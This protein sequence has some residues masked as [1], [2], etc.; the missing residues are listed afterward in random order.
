MRRQLHGVLE[1]VQREV[2]RAPPLDHQHQGLAERLAAS[3]Q[4]PPPPLLLPSLPPALEIQ[5]LVLPRLPLLAALPPLAVLPAA[6][7]L[8]PSLP[9]CIS[10]T[11]GL[12]LSGTS[13]TT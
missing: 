8:L 13:N 9:A 6:A 5:P 7:P 4:W 3:L 12:R 10:L 1:G 11:T 2:Q